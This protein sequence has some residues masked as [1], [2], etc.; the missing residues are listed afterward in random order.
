MSIEKYRIID[1]NE[2]L[3]AEILDMFNQNGKHDLSLSDVVENLNREHDPRP[4]D[5]EVRQAIWRLIDHGFLSILNN[6]RLSL[7]KK[8][9]G[10]DS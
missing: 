3:E 6:R 10:R 5:V 4:K 1:P 8:G 2:K 9:D 7:P